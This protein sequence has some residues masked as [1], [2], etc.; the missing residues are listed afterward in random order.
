MPIFGQLQENARADTE[1]LIRN[2]TKGDLFAKP[3]DVDFAFKTT[4]GEKAKDLNEFV[5][6][7]NF[8][9]SHVASGDGG[10]F[11]VFVVIH[12]PITQN[13][14]CSLSGF[15]VCLARLF[16]VEYDGWGSVLKLR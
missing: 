8:G 4:D 15:M 9:R 12:T 11:W 2:D 5:N 14:I 13:V 16:E 3:R 10:I 6:G 7:Q 1:Q